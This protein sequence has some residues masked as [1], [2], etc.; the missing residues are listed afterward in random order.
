MIEMKIWQFYTICVACGHAGVVGWHLL[1][2]I[3][4]LLFQS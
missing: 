3:A 4:A 2:W 1:G